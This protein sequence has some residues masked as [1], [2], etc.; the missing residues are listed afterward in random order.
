MLVWLA[1]YPRSGNSL[2]LVT[3]KEAF[4]APLG[5]DMPGADYPEWL[6]APL[7][8]DVGEA[9]ARSGPVFVKTHSR[10]GLDGDRAIYIVRD[11]RD[12]TVSYAHFLKE[13]QEGYADWPLNR[14]ARMLIRGFRAARR[15]RTWAES[16]R[17]WSQRPNTAV[18]RFE[19]LITDPVAVIR[20]AAEEVGV[21]LPK[22]AGKP[23]DFAELHTRDPTMYRRGE[24]GA[25][26]EE[27]HPQLEEMFWEQQG[28]T[29]I[30]LGYSR[31]G[32]QRSRVQ[33]HH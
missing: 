7:I 15:P 11:G 8:R 24:P 25:W 2:S 33:A 14:I 32:P 12:A 23:P 29:M 28:K 21:S 18:V 20:G 13:S 5:S 17:L 16:V 26:R 1:S 27:L 19:E 30:S 22:P 3:L 4:G 31:V 6:R 9:R 10:P